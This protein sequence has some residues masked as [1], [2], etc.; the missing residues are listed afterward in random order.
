MCCEMLLIFFQLKDFSSPF[1]HSLGSGWGRFGSIV[2]FH[3][4][5][6]KV[7]ELAAIAS[8]MSSIDVVEYLQ[9]VIFFQVAMSK[10][11]SKERNATNGELLQSMKTMNVAVIGSKV[12][13]VCL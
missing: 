2:G 7:G 11:R 3:V 13:S 4:P 1:H 10:L 12:C 8:V 5:M 6:W 9:D